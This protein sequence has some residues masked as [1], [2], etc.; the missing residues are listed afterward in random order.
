MLQKYYNGNKLLNLRDIDGNVPEIYLSVG[1]RSSGKTT[2]FNK[3]M[4]DWYKKCKIR[5]FALLYRYAY[6]LPDCAGKFFNDIQ[7][8][9]FQTDIMTS[10]SKARG[11][12]FELLLND[13]CC[14]Y[15][16]AINNSEQIKKYSHFFNDIDVILFD[17]F[18]PETNNYCPKEITKFM[19]IHTS[20][21]RGQGKSVRYVPVIMIS[22]AVTMINPYYTEFGISTRLKEDTKYLRGHG[23][24]LEQSYN[25]YA[26]QAQ[27]ESGFNRA[28]SENKYLQSSTE[29]VYL[30]DSQSFIENIK[31]KNKYLCTIRYNNTDYGIREYPEIGVVYCSPNADNSYP[32]KLSVTT[33][34]HNI[35][36]VM[37]KHN[38]E[39]INVFRYYFENGCFRFKDLRS[40][41]AVM[42]ALSY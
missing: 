40:K 10:V 38:K 31:G 19:S 5:K 24:V 3:L 18:Q 32:I 25:P 20:I 8:L 36:Y 21:A 29:N 16:I 23:F 7:G 37:L 12:Y 39:I 33:E 34:D 15:A 26:A 11:T 17:E 41:E 35:N 2:Y 6:E 28:F 1:N 4:I 13:V 14:G 22:N 27:K 30:N 9:F 42:T